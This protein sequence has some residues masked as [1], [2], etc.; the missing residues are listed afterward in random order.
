MRVHALHEKFYVDSCE[1]SALNFGF[2]MGSKI[3]LELIIGLRTV[4]SIRWLQERILST[5]RP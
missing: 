5:Q 3:R 4:S 2:K 1:K